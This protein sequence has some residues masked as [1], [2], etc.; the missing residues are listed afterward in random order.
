MACG[1]QFPKGRSWRLFFLL[2]FM[3]RLCF[4][5]FATT[6]A[7]LGTMYQR[8][9]CCKESLLPIDQVR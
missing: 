2:W 4:K 1:H 5:D 3:A 8:F 9:K 7:P 6:N